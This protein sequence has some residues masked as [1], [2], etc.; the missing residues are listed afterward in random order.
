M[1]ILEGPD[2][3]GKSTLAQRIKKRF[4]LA[5]VTSNSKEWNDKYTP[6]EIAIA[7]RFQLWPQ[8]ILRDRCYAI[9]EY[10]Y[11]RV[12]RGGPKLGLEHKTCL[13]DLWHRP[14]LIIYCRPPMRNICQIENEQME[15][16]KENIQS[17]VEEYDNLMGE[18]AIN[19]HCQVIRYDYTQ[20]TL[21]ELF[22]VCKVYLDSLTTRIHS[23]EYVNQFKEIENDTSSLSIQ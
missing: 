17:I 10:I 11:G 6:A 16:V 23:V 7:S 3:A 4:D 15:G 18:I 14:Y 12:L 22:A 21:V 5:V 13:M 2:N 1:I 8:R 9:S 20:T 19:S